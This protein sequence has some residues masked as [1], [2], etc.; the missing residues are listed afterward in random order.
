MLYGTNTLIFDNAQDWLTFQRYA[1][2]N[3]DK[4]RLVQ[5]QMKNREEDLESAEFELEMVCRSL[6]RG[7]MCNLTR[8]GFFLYD[9]ASDS[10]CYDTDVE[11]RLGSI[12]TLAENR[13]EV[14]IEIFI[15]TDDVRQYDA[16]FAKRMHK[17]FSDLEDPKPDI[18][19][20]PCFSDLPKSE[21]ED[22]DETPRE[23][24][25]DEA[26]TRTTGSGN[27]GVRNLAN[28]IIS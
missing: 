20:I 12:V 17:A 16:K 14:N 2:L 23:E 10:T 25:S 15:K 24:N 27:R 5:F 4:I 6:W 26:T 19:L 8:I 28:N 9:W 18:T 13:T 11:E 3:T 7:P 21:Y 22:S 1:Y